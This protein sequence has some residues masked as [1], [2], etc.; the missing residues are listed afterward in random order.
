M[1]PKK[2]HYIWLGEGKKSNLSHIC[3]NSWK[4]ELFD[5]E[6]IEWNENK[7]DLD[8]LA[9]KNRFFAECRKRKL[10]AYMA[11]YLR[12]VV[13]YSEG[14]IYLDTDVQVLKS[15]DPLL[16]HS[17]CFGMEAKDYI[18]TGMMAC[19]PGN[20]VIKKIL[21]FYQD[22][23][24]DSNLF[25]IPSIIT[26]I[27]E[28][29]PELKNHATIYPMEYFAP[30][31]PWQSYDDNCVTKNTYCIHWFQG[32]WVDSPGLRRFLDVK[33]IKNPMVKAAKIIKSEI[34]VICRK[35]KVR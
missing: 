16:Q 33:H 28:Q 17:C 4:K 1:I 7:L 23:I 9:S 15:F 2:V 34:G 13:L 3:I 27:F 8:E 26:H 35:L 22:E 24:W 5:Y 31:D 32:G 19:E 21:D 18:G 11:D 12:L 14:G 20:M 30:Y 29:N 10:W 25:T 6:I